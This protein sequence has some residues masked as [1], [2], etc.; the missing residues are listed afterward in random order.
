MKIQLAPSMM[1]S[2]YAHLA[3]DLRLIKLGGADLL[4][5]DI[6]DGHYVPNLIVGPDYIKTLRRESDIPLDLHLMVEQPEL[7]VDMFDMQAGER[8][9]FHIETTYHPQ[10]LVAQLRDKGLKVGIAL[11]PT[12]PY[13]SLEYLLDDIDFIHLMLVNP[14]YAGQPLLKSMLQKLRDIRADLDAKGI[15][16]DLEVDG[17]VSYE[18]AAEI[19]SFGA[20]TLVLGAYAC[21]DNIYG[22]EAGIK[23][24][25]ELVSAQ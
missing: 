21:F 12:V 4:H 6:M 9:C 8:C 7:F 15:E 2:N 17:C 20:T 1:C 11:A 18:N 22:I 23:K 3:E 16:M 14:G 24:V 13:S 10:R 5:C 19:V 25:R